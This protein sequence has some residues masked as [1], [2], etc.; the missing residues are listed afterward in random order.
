[1]SNF[2]LPTLVFPALFSFAEPQNPSR[3][4]LFHILGRGKIIHCER[5]STDASIIGMLKFDPKHQP[6]T[7]TNLLLPAAFQHYAL[8][9]GDFSSFP[10]EIGLEMTSPKCNQ[11]PDSTVAHGMIEV[12]KEPENAEIIACAMDTVGN[13]TGI[14]RYNR[15]ETSSKTMES[16]VESGVFSAPKNGYY[17]ITFSGR[18]TKIR[19]KSGC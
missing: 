13:V 5:L 14:V 12:V 18:L 9:M 2:S 1:M 6:K 11:I 10:L 7:S 4:Q 19:I 15:C 8:K 17:A 16:T 3:E